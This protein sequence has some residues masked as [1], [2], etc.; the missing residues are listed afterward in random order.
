M[1]MILIVLG[2]NI[3]CVTLF[4]DQDLE[5]SK[6]SIFDDPGRE[7]FGEP[8]SMTGEEMFMCIGA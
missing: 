7:Y 5:D 1:C 6:E 8:I 4:D 3:S 2:G